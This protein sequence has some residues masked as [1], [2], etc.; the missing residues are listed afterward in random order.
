MSQAITTKY[1]GPT[2]RLGSRIKAECQATTKTFSWDYDCNEE[3][4]HYHAAMDIAVQLGW[5]KKHD[6]QGGQMKDGRY[7]WVLIPRK[8]GIK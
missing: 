7:C 8:R 2:D 6:L 4:N 1:L 3:M 5:D